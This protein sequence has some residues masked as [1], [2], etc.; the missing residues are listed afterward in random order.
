MCLLS[1]PPFTSL[2][3]LRPIPSAHRLVILL[4]LTCQDRSCL[5]R[6]DDRARDSPGVRVK[7]LG[8]YATAEN[9]V[10]PGR[11]D[12][13]QPTAFGRVLQAF[14]RERR[15]DRI[16]RNWGHENYF[17]PGYDDGGVMGS[18]IALFGCL[19]DQ[20]LRTIG[21]IEVGEWPRFARKD[22]ICGSN[23]CVPHG[24]KAPAWARAHPALCVP[25][26][27]RW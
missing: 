27:P 7:T 10:R 5:K 4:V 9:D 11:G 19:A 17:V 26:G 21:E 23:L 25:L 18:Q 6:G 16:I 13:A 8:G 22:R 1:L 14:T 20:A 12:T 24:G 3:L 2:A 15:Q